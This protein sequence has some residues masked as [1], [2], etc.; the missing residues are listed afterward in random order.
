M[1]STERQLLSSDPNIADGCGKTGKG[2][3]QASASGIADIGDRHVVVGVFPMFEFT[4]AK[5]LYSLKFDMYV[6]APLVVQLLNK[7]NKDG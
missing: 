7:A 3:Y 5:C 2:G 4:T 6:D 1:L